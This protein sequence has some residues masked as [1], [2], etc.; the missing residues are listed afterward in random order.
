M[1][2]D[3]CDRSS[4]SDDSIADNKKVGDALSFAIRNPPRIL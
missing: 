2:V 3:A 1:F 4:Y